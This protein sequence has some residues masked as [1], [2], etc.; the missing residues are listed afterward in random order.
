MDKTTR[1][2]Q[3]QPED[4]MTMASMK[5]QGFS[6]RAMARALDRSPST[7]T[8]E[9]AAQHAGGSA[10]RLAHGAGGL[11]EP[12]GG[13]PA[14]GQ[15]GLQQ[16]GLGRGAHDAGLEVVAAA[17]SRYPQARVPRRTRAAR[18]PRDHLHGH[19]RPAARRVAP[20][21]RGV[22]APWPQHAHASLAGRTTG[23]ARSPTWSASMSAR[24]R[25]TIA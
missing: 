25:W 18:L 2:Q 6:A 7:I 12:A 23:A 15:A 1:Y 5:Q 13:R 14:C 10:V 21:A 8:R 4:R 19:L 24:P 11:H 9:L 17:D 20:A 22:S 16:R 3:L